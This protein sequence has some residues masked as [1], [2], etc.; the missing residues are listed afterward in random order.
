MK[1][2]LGITTYNRRKYL[3]HLL[4]SFKPTYNKSYEWVIIIND[5]AST[6]DTE[7]FLANYEFPCEHHIITNSVRKGVSISTNNI[8]EKA[9]QIGFDVL[10]KSDDDNYFMN[11]GWDD[12]YINILNTTPYKHLSYYNNRWKGDVNKKIIEDGDLVSASR[13]VESMGNFY[14]ITP[15]ILEKVG[16]LD[17]QN[18]GMWG[19]EHI[20]YSLRC[21]RAGFNN[22]DTF[23][24]P[25]NC[26]KL[27]GMK[28]GDNYVSSMTPQELVNER[29]RD[30]QKRMIA[31]NPNRIYI[32]K[33]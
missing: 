22:A 24:S 33:N 8:F 17:S 30:Y 16:Y 27:I 13:V 14:T 15:E 11:N 31:N 25:K 10:F 23:W 28:T 12:L 32:P 6:D 4:D 9:S 29:S 7:I 26:Y 2:I 19:V 21:C 20:D 3:E 5:D 1:C 18:M